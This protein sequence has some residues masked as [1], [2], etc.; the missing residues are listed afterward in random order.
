MRKTE[1]SKKKPRASVVQTSRQANSPINLM[2]YHN[3]S[4]FCGEMFDSLREAV[5][6]ID[7]AIDKILRL[8]GN[9]E[10]KC[11]SAEGERHLKKFLEDVQVGASGKGMKSFLHQYLDRLLTWGTAVCEIVPFAD[12]TVAA[13]YCANNKD[14]ELHPTDNPL[15]IKICSRG[16]GE[17]R[18]V[19]NP[20][21]VIVTALNPMPGEICGSS[22]LRGLPFVSSILLKI[23]N[24][25]GVNWERIGIC[26]M[27][28]PISHPII[29]SMRLSA[30]THFPKFLRNGQGL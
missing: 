15:Q 2:S 21:R 26:V 17:T 11:S 1:K 10:I 18:E 30:P 16:V 7:A 23:I 28:L 13:I 20:E 25:I 5:P 14:I 19:P 27:Q 4:F 24:T 8:I 9:V 22:I 29:F 12:G 6:I 3:D